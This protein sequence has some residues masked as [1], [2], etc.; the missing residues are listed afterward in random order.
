MEIGVGASTCASGNQVCTGT[1]GTLLPAA[2]GYIGTFD[3]LTILGLLSYGVDYHIAAAFAVTVHIILWL[4]L[5]IAGSLC[6]L[7]P[8]AYR[9]MTWRISLDAGVHD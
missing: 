1:L 3:Y 9:S 2:P 7:A 6:L 4:P 5:T 8:G